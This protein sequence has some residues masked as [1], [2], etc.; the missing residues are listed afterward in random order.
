MVKKRE[1]KRWGILEETGAAE[2]GKRE[3]EIDSETLNKTEEKIC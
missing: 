1:K 2:K 3:R